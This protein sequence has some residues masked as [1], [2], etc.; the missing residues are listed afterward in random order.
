MRNLWR[1]ILI[2]L[3]K[4]LTTDQD[5]QNSRSV[6]KIDKMQLSTTGLAV[7]ILCISVT[8]TT[9]QSLIVRGIGRVRHTARELKE[10][11]DKFVTDP[12]ANVEGKFPLLLII[13][14]LYE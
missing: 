7:A 9:V 4:A 13:G 12:S 10:D 6:H 14:L 3:L 8:C 1:D 2:L 11:Q 5:T